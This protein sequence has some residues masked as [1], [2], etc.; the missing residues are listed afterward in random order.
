MGYEIGEIA[1]MERRLAELGQVV[2]SYDAYSLLVR[3]AELLDKIAALLSEEVF[4][5]VSAV[6]SGGAALSPGAAPEG[7]RTPATTSTRLPRQVRAPHP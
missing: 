6:A 7:T 5:V 1:R 3:K 4:R 2:I